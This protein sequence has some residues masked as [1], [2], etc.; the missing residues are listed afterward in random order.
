M[1]NMPAT[2]E[3]PRSSAPAKMETAFSS[4]AGFESA[5]RMAKALSSSTM[6]PKS[7]QGGEHGLANCIVALELAQRVGASPFA[8]F[9]NMHVIQGRPSWSSS[10]IIAALNSCGRFA[11]LKFDM[12]GQG[13]GYG[14]TAWTTDKSTGDRL[15]GPKVT[16]GMAKAE[17]W[18]S[19]PG[20]K[21]KTMP[22]LML[23][24]RA[25]AFFGRLYAPD[26]LMGMHSDDE[27]Q[28]MGVQPQTVQSITASAPRAQASAPPAQ[29]M[30]AMIMGESKEGV[31]DEEDAAP[32]L[33]PEATQ[34]V[35]QEA[36]PVSTKPTSSTSPKPTQEAAPAPEQRQ[37]EETAAEKAAKKRMSKAELDELRACAVDSITGAGQNVQEW[38]GRF[39]KFSRD[40]TEKQCAEVIDTLN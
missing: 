3:Q 9:Q 25:A 13:D 17:G 20:S 18:M 7:Y 30:N 23:R 38:E 10:F 29:D 14:C 4:I 1:E 22:E 33:E 31:R 19:K 15:D 32:T 24:Y 34:E 39:N 40:W 11:P 21:W 35:K 5:M 8:V 27:V 37:A 6:V 28:D 2:V 12:E 26:V 16:I 36:A